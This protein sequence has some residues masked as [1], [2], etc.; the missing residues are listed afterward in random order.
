MLENAPFDPVAT[1]RAVI[2]STIAGSLATLDEAGNPFATLVTMATLPDG[3]P[4]LSLSDLA[5]HTH[6]LKRDPRA[7]MLLVAPGGEGGNPLAGARI[8]LVGTFER[9]DDPHVAWRYALHQGKAASAS[10]LPGFH[11]Y[12]MNVTG[13]HLVAG[14]GNIAQVPAKD[15]IQD[16]SDCEDLLAGEK[17]VVEHMNDDHA[18]AIALYAI[19]LLNLPGGAWRITGCDPEGIDIA[20]SKLRARLPFPARATSVAEAGGYLKSFAKQARSL[21]Q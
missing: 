9:S 21:E 13:S 11:H 14:F 10:A 7:S 19:K 18:D 15:L 1:G 17:M 6:N 20:T 4:I 8:T 12:V 5:V 3:R 16:L 2:R